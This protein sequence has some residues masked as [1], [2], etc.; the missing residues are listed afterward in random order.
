MDRERFSVLIAD[1]EP[2]TLRGIESL[3]KGHSAVWQIVG[4]C[5]NG[6]DALALLAKA[7]SLDLLIT[8]IRMPQVDGLSLIRKARERFPHLEVIIISGFAEF[9]YAQTAITLDVRHF[10]LK[11]IQHSEMSNCLSLIY[12][13]L[14]TQ[15]RGGEVWQ[16]AISRLRYQSLLFREYID[17]PLAEP[18]ELCQLLSPL[19]PQSRLLLLKTPHPDDN[20]IMPDIQM[21][22]LRRIESIWPDCLIFTVNSCY[23]ALVV[24]ACEDA[25]LEQLLPILTEKHAY[26]GI[27]TPFC[28]PEQLR[29]AYEEAYI[30]VHRLLYCADRHLLS[31][32]PADTEAPPSFRKEEER[33][34]NAIVCG[35][36]ATAET[37]VE[38]ILC[39]FE[40][41]E[42]PPRL[43]VTQ[44]GRIF[45]ILRD[46]LAPYPLDNEPIAA[47]FDEPEKM[48]R[49]DS[50]D[51]FSARLLQ[52]VDDAALM[53]QTVVERRE[54]R[55]VVRIKQ[56]LADNYKADISLDDIATAVDM[57]S[58]YISSSFKQ[59]TGQTIIEYLTDL[60]IEQ[61][62]KLLLGTKLKSYEIAALV[63]YNDH[64]YF[65]RIFKKRVGVSPNAF[66]SVASS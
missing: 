14:E 51:E 19:T 35:D 49:A 5:A 64:H 37:E 12:D 61:A 8:D 62:K 23:A 25:F 34:T 20:H 41:S 10:L 39:Y 6:R 47:I 11:P 13:S 59:A 33:L 57:N 53:I 65:H 38:T 1:D 55:N 17:N 66:R 58:S 21:Q 60:R 42:A 56:Y 27:S 16:S 7:D 9:E 54:N 50:F 52:I 32:E 30:A 63:G 18:G 15:R 29:A 28:R 44:V 22:T 4:R 3:I 2:R 31:Y 24:G 45:S 40:K 43:L 46:A 26:V 48:L 36:V